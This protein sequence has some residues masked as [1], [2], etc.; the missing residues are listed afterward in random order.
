MTG[1]RLAAAVLGGES[2]CIIR[3]ENSC[4]G[5]KKPTAQGRFGRQGFGTSEAASFWKRGSFRS[6]SNIAPLQ[7][8]E[9]VLRVH[10]ARLD[11]AHLTTALYLYTVT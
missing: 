11:E 8:S 5:R 3:R 4:V 2:L 10:S 9:E 7:L 6:G 1:A